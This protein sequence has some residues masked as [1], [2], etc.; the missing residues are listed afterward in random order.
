MLFVSSKMI[1][2]AVDTNMENPGNVCR[3]TDVQISSD[4][5]HYA[6]SD[7]DRKTQSLTAYL[8]IN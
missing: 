8:I 4:R 7:K 1:I 3:S 6:A 5:Q 2:T